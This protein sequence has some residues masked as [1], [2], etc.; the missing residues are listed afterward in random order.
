MPMCRHRSSGPPFD[1]TAVANAPNVKGECL[2]EEGCAHDT[3]TLCERTAVCCLSQTVRGLTGVM[4]HEL[5]VAC[6]SLSQSSP[7][8][9]V[10]I[11][12]VD[13]FERSLTPFIG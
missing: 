8:N 3:D 11:L 7:R 12:E 5:W 13:M 4:G 9:L 1:C 6:S 10:T 2:K